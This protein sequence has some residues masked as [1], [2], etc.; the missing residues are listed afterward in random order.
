MSD[1]NFQFNI[2][3]GFQNDQSNQN[4]ATNNDQNNNNPSSI[5]YNAS[6][7][8]ISTEHFK[9]TVE[10]TEYTTLSHKTHNISV[11]IFTQD[12]PKK[13]S[14]TKIPPTQDRTYNIFS[15]TKCPPSPPIIDI[16]I[17]E[18]HRIIATTTA[19][20]LKVQVNN[21]QITVSPKQHKSSQIYDKIFNPPPK[22]LSKYHVIYMD[23]SKLSKKEKTEFIKRGFYFPSGAKHYMYAP[24]TWKVENDQPKTHE[25]QQES[26][27]N[28][29]KLKYN[30]TNIT[31]TNDEIIFTQQG[32]LFP[33]QS[34]IHF[35]EKINSK[36]QKML[37]D[38]GIT[39]RYDHFWKKTSGVLSLPNGWVAYKPTLNEQLKNKSDEQ[40]ENKSANSQLKIYDEYGDEQP[41]LPTSFTIPEPNL[42]K[43]STKS[44]PPLDKDECF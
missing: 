35:Y 12:S 33:Q 13:P 32:V 7:K 14:I 29:L 5:Q 9:H 42:P 19:S 22:D 1:F 10:T 2:T 39:I 36:D 15:R 6:N 16:H 24:P 43:L 23:I 41:P 31:N 18:Q 34:L 28:T 30:N 38:Q 27:K 17:G 40:L 25:N 4:S 8:S 21:N 20:D 26:N 11:R 3:A 37:Q 44:S